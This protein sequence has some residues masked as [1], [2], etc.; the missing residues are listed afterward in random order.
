MHKSC[1]LLSWL[2]AF[3]EKLVVKFVVSN[4]FSLPLQLFEHLYFCALYFCTFTVFVLCILLGV[5]QFL[6]QSFIVKIQKKLSVLHKILVV[7]VWQRRLDS[8]QGR[9]PLLRSLAIQEREVQIW[10][11]CKIVNWGATY[12]RQQVLYTLVA[13]YNIITYLYMCICQILCK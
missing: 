12:K 6:Y 3:V 10:I 2:C 5:L 4:K 11:R 8:F 1:F 7:H 9:I 13:L